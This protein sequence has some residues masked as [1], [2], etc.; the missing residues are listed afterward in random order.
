MKRYLFYLLVL[1]VSCQPISNKKLV[2]YISWVQK[3]HVDEWQIWSRGI[4]PRS[5][6]RLLNTVSDTGQFIV[7]FDS[8]EHRIDITAWR[9]GIESNSS[10]QVRFVVPYSGNIN[11]QVTEIKQILSDTLFAQDLVLENV[12]IE[13]RRSWGLEDDPVLNN[14]IMRVNKREFGSILF[15]VEYCKS[16]ELRYLDGADDDEKIII[17]G[18]GLSF[19]VND[20]L[21]H[22]YK[23]PFIVG[24]SGQIK[25]DVDLIDVRENFRLNYIVVN[26]F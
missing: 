18:R 3:G 24:Y 1:F 5:Q 6:W 15:N 4:D 23:V 2:A 25:I 10:S 19:G 7:R 17:N 26:Y 14:E 12:Y 21:P 8:G 9:D 20:D 13:P 11:M 16:I 22:T